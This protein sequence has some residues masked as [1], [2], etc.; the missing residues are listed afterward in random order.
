[1]T[2]YGEAASFTWQDL[3]RD[4]PIEPRVACFIDLAH[5]AHADLGSD[6]I[7]A[8]AGARSQSHGKWLRL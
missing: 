6:L 8:E 2:A 7:R 5:A 4:R 1:M 3:D